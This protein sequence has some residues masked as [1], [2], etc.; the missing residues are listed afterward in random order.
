MDIQTALISLAIFAISAGI[1][2]FIAM[3]GMK[4]K[5]YEEAL[6]EQRQ[7]ANALLGTHIRTKPKEKK[8]KKANKKVKPC[9]IYH[10]L[11]TFVFF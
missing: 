4:E 9:S 6:A 7:Q 1:L 11:C 10:N 5:S 8:T 3:F 2:I